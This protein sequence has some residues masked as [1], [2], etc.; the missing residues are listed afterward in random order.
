M[1]APSDDLLVEPN[2]DPLWLDV[3]LLAHAVDG[4]TSDTDAARQL[5]S[6][7]NAPSL[8]ISN[9]ISTDGP[10]RSGVAAWMSTFRNGRGNNPPKDS[11]AMPLDWD[12]TA[13]EHDDADWS[14]LRAM[15]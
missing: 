4:N 7:G 13:L 6:P 15:W 14:I 9:T 12:F 8:H 5:R 11:D 1:F 3:L 10:V 2:H